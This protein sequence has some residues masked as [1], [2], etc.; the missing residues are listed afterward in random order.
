MIRNLDNSSLYFPQDERISFQEEGHIYLLD[1]T[2]QLTPV[3]IVYS[4]YFTPFDSDY[5]AE[6]KAQY[7]PITAQQLKEQWD[8]NGMM[9]SFV[10]THMHKQ[11]E[12]YLNGDKYM[13]PMCHFTY[14][15]KYIS[16]DKIHLG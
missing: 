4:K 1:G 13:A 2:R 8:C 12:E 11:I 14:K 6:R 10:G 9:A 5:W 3:S 16:E 7:L 15:G